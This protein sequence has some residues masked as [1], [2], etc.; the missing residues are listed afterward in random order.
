MLILIVVL[1]CH[2]LPVSSVTGGKQMIP[3][4]NAL[5]VN[6]AVFGNHD[7][8]KFINSFLVKAVC[9][10]LIL[11][12]TCTIVCLIFTRQVLQAKPVSCQFRVR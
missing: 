6:I 1:L 8:G 5:N 9:P 3:I 2:F 7:F 10:Q 12:I 4:L 11:I